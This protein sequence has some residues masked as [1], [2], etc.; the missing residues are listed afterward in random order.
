MRSAKM[1]GGASP[2]FKEK[3]LPPFDSAAGDEK[4]KQAYQHASWILSAL[5]MAPSTTSAV[6]RISYALEAAGGRPAT[7]QDKW[8]Y[9]MDPPQGKA[10][11][12]RNFCLTILEDLLV[13][14]KADELAE[15]KRVIQAFSGDSADKVRE[16]YTFDLLAAFVDV[17]LPLL[18]GGFDALAKAMGF[19]EEGPYKW[20]HIVSA[21]VLPPPG[22]YTTVQRARALATAQGGVAAALAAL[23]G[24]GEGGGGAESDAPAPAA[25]AGKRAR[26]RSADAPA[27]S[28]G[29]LQAALDA[30]SRKG[31]TRLLQQ[32]VERLGSADKPAHSEK[33]L[34][35]S[36]AATTKARE[37]V[38]MVPTAS[39]AHTLAATLAEAAQDMLLN[40]AE[41]GDEPPAGAMLTLSV[42]S[43]PPWARVLFPKGMASINSLAFS[44]T[45]V[46]GAGTQPAELEA[47]LAAALIGLEGND[48][49]LFLGDL[50][51]SMPQFA[52]AQ[53]LSENS[54]TPCL[55]AADFE[56]LPA[57]KKALFGTEQ[58]T[59]QT[60]VASLRARVQRL[61]N[62]V[63]SVH[64]QPAV[65]AA[66]FNVT[67][68]DAV[69]GRLLLGVNTIH[70]RQAAARGAETIYGPKPAPRSGVTYGYA[71]YVALQ[72]LAG[73]VAILAYNQRMATALTTGTFLVRAGGA[74]AGAVAAAA[75]PVEH[76]AAEEQ[77]EKPALKAKA[78]AK[79][80]GN[81]AQPKAAGGDAEIALLREQL[82]SA[83][84]LAKQLQRESKGLGKTAR[85]GESEEEEED[86]PAK[87]AKTTVTEWA[88]LAEGALGKD[89]TFSYKTFG[90][91]FCGD[92]E[93]RFARRC[94]AVGAK[95]QGF[96][97]QYNL[98]GKTRKEI[99]SVFKTWT[100]A[101]AGGA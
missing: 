52:T 5:K 62:K 50:T 45:M 91:P 96:G 80:K 15:A 38:G 79:A 61:E 30:P 8:D 27:R 32:L 33:A 49:V 29:A 76:E 64:Y 92:K 24:G 60:L 3:R 69:Y 34:L 95:D 74:G 82:A 58:G 73:G 28:A 54:I 86:R 57:A 101:L 99:K 75:A 10:G 78:K 71:L 72:A 66:G 55:S 7:E 46:S 6:R 81:G 35:Q 67:L 44:P 17:N 59:G 51:G 90:C 2:A 97:S 87:R 56:R 89:E 25:L 36:L 16:V 14:N 84:S 42:D 41:S 26:A 12:L 53:W 94:K 70:K 11:V 100:A 39:P 23:R 19:E 83:R 20:C 9:H 77:A 4:H 1:G 63:R 37:A 22:M 47:A 88:I 18:G 21:F 85:Q 93:C 43:M 98:E 65:P 31:E 13:N 48:N 40:A 68:A